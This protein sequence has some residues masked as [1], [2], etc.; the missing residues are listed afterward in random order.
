MVLGGQVVVALPFPDSQRW[1][2]WPLLAMDV[3]GMPYRQTSMAGFEARHERRGKGEG[4]EEA[5]TTA[6]V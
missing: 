4:K 6:T 1:T 3:R 5:S 2:L